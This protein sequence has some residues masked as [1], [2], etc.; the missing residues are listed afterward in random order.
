MLHECSAEIVCYILQYLKIRDIRK[1]ALQSRYLRD[2][3]YMT[4]CTEGCDFCNLVD[5]S[6]GKTACKK[7]KVE[8]FRD[9]G[10]AEC[11]EIVCDLCDSSR[12]ECYNCK[13]KMCLN[14]ACSMSRV[15]MCCRDECTR[16]VCQAC[17]YPVQHMTP[18]LCR[19]HMLTF[20]IRS[21]N[22]SAITAYY[23]ARRC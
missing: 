21:G 15:N 5:C 17:Y 20:A 2:V 19:G 12:E 14:G 8:K 1:I 16:L 11:H 18:P 4:S 22:S 6:C 23:R 7:C 13:K 9:A 3:A 10:C